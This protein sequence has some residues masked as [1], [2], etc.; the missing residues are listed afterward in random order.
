VSGD[1]KK[2][3]DLENQFKIESNVYQAVDIGGSSCFESSDGN[4]EQ[5]G[6]G[7]A[8]TVSKK[9]GGSKVGSQGEGRKSERKTAPRKSRNVNERTMK[10][11]ERSTLKRRSNRKK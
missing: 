9:R 5:G 8:S 1:K 2:E 10:Y 6:V 7:K 3:A 11:L 4:Q